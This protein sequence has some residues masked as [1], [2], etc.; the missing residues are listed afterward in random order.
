MLNAMN[1]F[2]HFHILNTNLSKTILNLLMLSDFNKILIFILNLFQMLV[3]IMDK[4]N[5]F[6]GIMRLFLSNCLNRFYIFMLFL[7]YLKK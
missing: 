5:V 2:I 1:S 3:V 6:I 4:S 7:I